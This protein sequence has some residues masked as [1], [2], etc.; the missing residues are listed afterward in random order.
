LKIKNII[1]KELIEKIIEELN[2]NTNQLEL[3]IYLRYGH[4]VNYPEI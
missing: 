1:K 3:A 2:M 4:L